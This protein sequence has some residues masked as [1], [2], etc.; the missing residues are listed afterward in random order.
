M[1][2]IANGKQIAKQIEDKLTKQVTE[3]KTKNIIPKLVVF[4][5]G[6]ND[7]SATYVRKK[8]EMAERIGVDFDLKQ[9]NGDMTE[10]E[11]IDEI[12]KAQQEKLSGLM[13]QLPLPKHIDAK[14]VINQINPDI[15][16]DCL[17]ENSWGKLT[18]GT[19]ILEPP[20]AGAMLEIL[21]QH[22]VDL[23]GKEVVVVGT[24]ELVG[25]PLI[26]M[27][28][29]EKCTITA[30]NIYT[31]DLSS[32]TKKADVIFSGV[33]KHNLITGDMIKKDAVVIDAGVSFHEGKMYGDIDFETVSKKASLVTPTPGG[34][35]PITVAKLLEN[36]VKVVAL[37]R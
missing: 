11:L 19:N 7:A 37:S 4:L 21:R 9:F 12:N 24:G 29:Q 6:N 22:K 17:T 2:T 30:C 33:G 14:K 27:L 10:Q 34:V 36:V 15:D 23:E 3:L 28:L 16:V 32:H 18:Q 35:G 20:T 1:P 8:G 25:K 31:K 5:I 26:L 13:I